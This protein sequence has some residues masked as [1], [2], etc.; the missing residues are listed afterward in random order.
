MSAASAAGPADVREKVG[1]R[2][3]YL[4]VVVLDRDARKDGFDKG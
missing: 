3:S 4:Q 1:V 2:A